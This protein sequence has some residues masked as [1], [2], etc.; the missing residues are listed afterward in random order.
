VPLLTRP[1]QRRTSTSATAYALLVAGTPRRLA[2]ARTGVGA[3]LLVRPRALPTLLGIDSA[4]GSR[5]AWS[6]SMLGAREVALGLGTLA[7]L[8][9]TDPRAARLWI[10]AGIL[11]DA[12]DV[13]AVGGAAVKGRLSRAPGGA[14][15]AGAAT[16]V[17]MGLR[18]LRD[19]A[20]AP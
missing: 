4:T 18:T 19:D 14:A 10:A 2:L 9:S 8:R 20:P 1:V 17:L 12:V 3:A 15:A 5:M 11:C 13:L 16:A 6:T 7:A